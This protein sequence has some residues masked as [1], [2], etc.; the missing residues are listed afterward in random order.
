M[1][2]GVPQG[3]VW[4]PVLFLTYILDID[5]T[6]DSFVSSFADDTRTMRGVLSL[7]DSCKLWRNLDEFFS[8]VGLQ[9]DFQ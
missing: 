2:S 5:V 9:H 6:A 8:W 7:E 3:T 1:V 4:E